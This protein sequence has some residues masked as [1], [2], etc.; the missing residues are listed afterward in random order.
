MS[1]MGNAR[2]VAVKALLDVNS[3][4]A[5]SNITLNK[6]LKNTDLNDVDKAFTTALF[7]GVLDRRI[8]LDYVL[9]LFVSKSLNRISPYT[10][11]ILRTALYQIMYMERV[12]DSA[13]VNEAVKLV[14][15][16]KERFNASFVNAV[17]RNALRTEITLPQGDSIKDL[18]IR[19]SCPE[20][21]IES[22]FEDY[23]KETA[24]AVLEEFL[25]VPNVVIR[26]NTL[27]TTA[28][29]L[30]EKLANEGT[31]TA[32]AENGNALIVSGGMDV[33]KSECYKAGLFHIQDTAS[34]RSIAVL[35]LKKGERVLDLCAAPGGKTFTMA[36]LMENKGEILAFDIYEKRVE[37]IASGAERLGIKNITAAIGDATV[38]NAALGKF[39]A[40]LCDVPCSGLGVL[41]R[42]PEIKYKKAD[43]TE[44]LLETQKK[45][46]ENAAEY[47]ASGGRML[48][49]TCTLRKA[50]N[51]DAVKAFLEKHPE[52]SLK[53]EHT[54]YPHIDKTDGFYCALLEKAR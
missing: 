25:N 38:Y 34:Q 23:G 21:I 3:S 7:Y 24:C 42:K 40:V 32:I 49:S 26:V 16:S 4:G 48:Y 27:R 46:M 19:Y 33:R 17:L 13:A 14:K 52:F 9:S 44:L 43:E 28:E 30:S 8:T 51:E 54:Y 36:Q 22:L 11:E 1:S 37:L 53:Y 12:P 5:Y 2:K 6:V 47:T 31:V 20:W 29:E 39:D 45:I 15:A 35:D 41:R 10:L 18:S 50:E